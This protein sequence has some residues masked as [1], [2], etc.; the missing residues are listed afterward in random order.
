MP[1]QQPAAGS[2][3]LDAISILALF[4]TFIAAIFAFVPF[5]A[6]PSVTA[7]TFLLSAGALITLALYILARLA[8]G[9]VIF[10]STALV[11][12][13]WLPTVAYALSAVFS[14]MPFTH[15]LWGVA[16]EPDTLGF[17]LTAACL[18]TLSALALRTADQYRSF[19]RF[20]AYVFGILAVLQAAIVIIGQAIPGKLSPSFSL[21]GSYTDLAFL[22][23]LG[24]VL[25][26]TT[27]RFVELSKRS[28]R[29]LIACGAVAL[30]LL[31][32]ANSSL[33]WTLVAIASL[34]LFVEAI[35]R[36]GPRSADTDL[37]ETEIL[38]E[39]SVGSDAGNHS[40]VLPLATLAIALFF[41]IGGTLGGALAKTLNVELVS[42]RPSWDSTISVAKK[43]YA[44]S[45]V[46]GSG[47]STF[48]NNW[49]KYRDASLNQSVFWNVDFTSGIGF[50]P[51]S[52]VTTGIV[53]IIAW[54]V[55]LGL[56]IALGLRAL[57][58]R[59]PQDPFIRYAAMAS[60]IGALYLFAAAV[61]DLPGQLVIALAFV[62][63]G[64]FV[65]T[66]RYAAGG[67]QRGIVFSRS[68][69]LGFVIVFSLTILMLAS[70]VAAYSLVGRYVSVTELSLAGSAG[71]LS[72]AKRHVQNSISFAPSSVA[73]Q[74]L[75]VIANAQLNAI[76][77]STTIDKA[78]ARDAYQKTLSD[79]VS[80]AMTATS[81]DPSDYRNW[82]SLGN[83]YAQAVPLNV[84]GAYDNAKAAYAKAKELNPTNPQIPFIIAQLDISNKDVKAAKEDLKAAIALKQ[85]YPQAIFLLSQLEV[86]DGNVK[87]ALAAALAANY[88]E[89]NNA[90]ILFQIGILSAAMNDYAT[91][92][93]ALERAVTANPQFANAYYF[94]SAVYAEQGNFSAA[95]EQLQK[96]ADL[97]AEN[98]SAVA[99]ALND[100]KSGKNPFPKNLLSIPSTPVK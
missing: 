62:F 48:G 67:R 77:A 88:F 61:F 33:I 49:L 96:V 60:F 29:A 98:A 40:L 80:A 100:L 95:A 97:S 20:G 45:P 17:M 72:A 52:L 13:L 42:V 19:F 46:F 24:V 6:I 75:A 2:R 73:Y 27:L 30:F 68:P 78:A 5:A 70:V 86:Q 25:A 58:L 63:A 34:G 92:A 59:T 38:S 65:S 51:T 28:Y 56:F 21:T 99:G 66:M 1:P 79:G 10:P 3:S 57:I 76:V 85:D 74:S 93:A 53:G 26:L 82:L 4:I 36:R 89:P 50:I 31:A 41:L 90:T 12:A 32:V 87:D 54:L 81:V 84:S 18:G 55:F 43:T 14:G 71:D 39:N 23:G 8:R 7:K 15:S 94:L 83:L 35:M 22:L 37:A 64:I 44:T 47:P 16:L 9:N 91:A 69:R 11:G